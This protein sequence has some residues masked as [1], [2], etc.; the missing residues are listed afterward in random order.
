LALV[1]GSRLGPC[2]ISH[3]DGADFLVMELLDG[4]TLAERLTRGPLPFAQTMRY[5]V[6]IAGA[7]DTAHRRGI[8]HRDLTLRGATVSYEGPG[9]PDGKLRGPSG[10]SSMLI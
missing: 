1:P 8:A 10:E 7:L 4:E 3:H 5:G 6:E 9:H 2:E